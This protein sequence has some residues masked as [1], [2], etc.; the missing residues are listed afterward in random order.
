M[1]RV[2]VTRAT[3]HYVLKRDIF[4]QVSDDLGDR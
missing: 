1:P 4:E 2:N 3:G